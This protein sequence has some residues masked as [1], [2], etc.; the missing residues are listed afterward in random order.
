MNALAGQYS[1]YLRAHA[2]QPVQ[3]VP[4]SGEL[5]TR[6]ETQN[7]LLFISI[8]YSAC[9]WCHVMARESY[10]RNDVAEALNS[11]FIPVKIDREEYP[12]IDRRYMEFCSR[13]VGRC[14]WPLHILALPDGTPFYA[15]TYL[16]PKDAH[17][18]KGLLSLVR[19]VCSQYQENPENLEHS[20]RGLLRIAEPGASVTASIAVQAESL[21]S[22]VQSHFDSAHGGYFGPSKFPHV[23]VLQFLMRFEYLLSREK[24]RESLLDNIH[25]QL[26]LT[27][28]SLARGGIRDH[29]EGGFFR[30]ATT[31][32]W[33]IPHYEKMLYDQALLIDF[34]TDAAVYHQNREYLSA[35]EE[36]AQFVLEKMSD[37]DGLFFSS[38]S[39]ES[40]DESGILR[41]GY[42][43]EGNNP[44]DLAERESARQRR[45][46]RV[47]PAL[48]TKISVGINALA[49]VGLV[50]LF[51]RTGI[52]RYGEAA[53][54]NY[55]SLTIQG[56]PP[57][58]YYGTAEK[59]IPFGQ[60]TLFDYSALGLAALSLW[61]GGL[62]DSL[63]PAVQFAALAEALIP[64]APESEYPDGAI[65]SAVSLYAE[66]FAK[67]SLFSPKE[68]TL[69]KEKILPLW[70]NRQWTAS[71]FALSRMFLQQSGMG[72]VAFSGHTRWFRE[73]LEREFFLPHISVLT[74]PSSDETLQGDN[75][76]LCTEG[77]CLPPAENVE[78]LF[79]RIND[80]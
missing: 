49:I 7:R 51:R 3:W 71:P 73:K 14:G 29:I 48:D 11:C 10:E 28:Y 55:V 15:F 76:W 4:W 33:D 80:L 37:T 75:A 22:Y 72:Y 31:P 36:A 56:T 66:L 5:F 64:A 41:E 2:E 6:P 1:E 24:E 60:P 12:E 69:T 61:E 62:T 18:K 13:T 54:Q 26:E 46:Q 8:G 20:A 17:G 38:T 39:A 47:P 67:L 59:R 70:K 21:L 78:Q 43:Y 19:W 52:I 77:R 16:P 53:K 40:P 65:P 45:F 58:I 35:A 23:P 74:H 42:Y 63:S 30:Y 79:E 25:G 44:Y 68:F 27:L 50:N 57:A 32:R 9:H 34:L